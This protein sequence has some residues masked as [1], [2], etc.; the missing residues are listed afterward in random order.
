LPEDAYRYP[1]PERWY[2]EWG[3]RRYG[4]HGMSVEWS[5]ERAA[6]LLARPAS[7][8]RLVVAHLGSGCSVTAVDGGRSVATSMGLTPLEG[9]MMGTRSGSIDPGILFYLRRTGRLS[10][11]E[12]ADQLDHESGLVGVS[13]RT[14]DVRELLALEAA[15]DGP[16]TLALRIFVRRAAECI[17]AAATSLPA[18]DAIV[19]TGGIGE[20]AAGLRARIVA[21]LASIG[22]APIEDAPVSR[23]AVISSSGTSPAILRVEAREDLVVARAA[24]ALVETARP[25]TQGL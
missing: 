7:G 16:A 10:D 2:R 25:G 17:A 24:V 1:V 9:L 19:F 23:D 15:G 5:A 21:R 11:D 14:S 4:F 20:N 18:L 6:Q 3:V 13:G 12:L 8:L 22:V